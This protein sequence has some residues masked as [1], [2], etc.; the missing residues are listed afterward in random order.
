[1]S[2]SLRYLG[3]SVVSRTLILICKTTHAIA[4]LF[5]LHNGRLSLAL[6]EISP[7][8]NLVR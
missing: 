6:H 1:M 2:L 3:Y 7:F 5:L 4:S 8:G